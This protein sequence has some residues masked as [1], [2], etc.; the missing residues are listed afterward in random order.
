[1]NLSIFI[2]SLAITSSMLFCASSSPADHTL[3]NF[4]IDTSPKTEWTTD[5]VIA[6][7]VAYNIGAGHN[8]CA[9]YEQLSDHTVYEWQTQNAHNFGFAFV[10]TIGTAEPLQ[11]SKETFLAA[12]A[13]E[14]NYFH[15]KESTWLNIPG[16][17]MQIL[18]YA[19]ANPARLYQFLFLCPD[20][21]LQYEITT[22]LNAPTSKRSTVAVAAQSLRMRMP[23]TTFVLF[24]V[25][26]YCEE[27]LGISRHDSPPKPRQVFSNSF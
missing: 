7:T 4:G 21:E 25:V 16:R 13:D 23:G 27:V 19:Y 10:P 15:V 2:A 14:T 18:A 9:Y 11:V 12:P 24:D 6:S 8:L 22:E 5:S 20:H 26:A 17:A 1:M 3:A